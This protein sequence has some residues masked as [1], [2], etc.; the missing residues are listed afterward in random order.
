MSERLQKVLAAE[1]LG[2]RR[3]IERW[4][5][6]GRITVNGDVAQLGLKVEVGDVIELDGKRVKV[7]TKKPERRVIIYNK[8]E[9]EVSTRSDPE[10]RKTVF[11]RLPVSK[12]ERWIAVG[13]LD[14]NTS[15]LLLFTNDG[16][17]ANVLM[18]PSS[19]IDR[20][21]AVRVK[22]EVDED[23]MRTLR[24]GVLLEDGMARFTD[25]QPGRNATG[26]N[27]WY[28]VVLMEGKNREV[29]RLWESQEVQVSR[30]KRVRFGNVFIPSS[31]KAG[32]YAELSKEQV[33][34]L[35]ELAGIVDAPVSFEGEAFSDQSRPAKNKKPR[36]SDNVG[37]SR[38]S[39]QSRRASKPRR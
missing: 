18:H 36:K 14:M 6:A 33:D 28:Y 7:E 37:K 20:E 5:E 27:S 35:T 8:P 10:G 22:G 39:D 11:D 25:I 17:L 38:M 4:I 9:G 15:G 2:S 1:G 34:S 30:L 21:Y 26:A 31:L 19:Q 32:K 16:E 24:E 3:E 29:R 12:G 13:R 23:T